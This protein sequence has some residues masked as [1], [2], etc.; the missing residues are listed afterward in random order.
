MASDLSTI[1]AALG[2]VAT[3]IGLYRCVRSDCAA[4]AKA[5]LDPVKENIKD[6]YGKVADCNKQLSKQQV[7]CAEK[8]SCE[9]RS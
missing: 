7:H 1:G 4:D 3:V 5:Q 2:T 9:K 8:Q 6:L